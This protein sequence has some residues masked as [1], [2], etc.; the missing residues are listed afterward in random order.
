MHPH[1]AHVFIDGGYLRMLA[2]EHS[3][4]LVHPRNLATV[5]MNSGP[6]QTWAFNPG[7]HPNAFLGRVVYYDA[8]PDDKQN[9]KED[10][11]EYWR[12]VELLEDVHLGFGAL[13][14]LKRNMRQKGVDTLMAVD[15]L[16]G[17]FSGL[18]DIAIL[19]AGDAD[20]VPVVEEV[21][22]R[23]VMVA[24]AG[25]SKSVSEDLRRVADRFIEIQKDDTW[26]PKMTHGTKTWE[27]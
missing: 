4:R 13:R 3:G 21:K 27:A 16:V 19:V 12:I 26:L 24:V 22:R 14:G 8:I 17:A 15:M 6:V 2:R 20:F 5:L 9:Q 25:F 11:E 7:Q 10:V 18:F 23:G 1:L